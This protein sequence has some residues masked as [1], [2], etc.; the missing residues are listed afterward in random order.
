MREHRCDKCKDTTRTHFYKDRTRASG[1]CRLCKSCER[2][3][4]HNRV[5]KIR[6]V[7]AQKN[8]VIQLLGASCICCGETYFDYLQLDHIHNDGAGHRRELGARGA[9]KIYSWALRNQ[10]QV[11]DRLQILCANCHLFKT[12]YKVFCKDRHNI[13]KSLV[14]SSVLPISEP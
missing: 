11:K 3:R 9:A 8:K 7:T 14:P 12:R 4:R 2:I 1:L 13:G 10:D 6:S 5:H